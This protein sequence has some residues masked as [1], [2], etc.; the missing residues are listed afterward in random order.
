MSARSRV[1]IS[2]E[3]VIER[4]AIYWAAARLPRCLE[5]RAETVFDLQER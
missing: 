1:G 2:P 3:Q 5:I 4:M